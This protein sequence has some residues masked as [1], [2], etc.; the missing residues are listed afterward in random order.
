MVMANPVRFRHGPS[1]PKAGIRTMIALGF[2]SLIR[3]HPRPSW[4]MTRGEKF[5]TTTSAHWTRR[6]ANA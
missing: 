3:S 5:S 6:S 4:S 2:S 1:S